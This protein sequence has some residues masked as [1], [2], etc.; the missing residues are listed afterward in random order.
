MVIVDLET[1]QTIAVTIVAPADVGL[2]E[3]D[4]RDRDIDKAFIAGG[5]CAVEQEEEEAGED[6]V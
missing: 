5:C 3:T 1:D 2:A 4:V 6:L